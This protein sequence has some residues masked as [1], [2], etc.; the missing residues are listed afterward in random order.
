M[1]IHK[2]GNRPKPDD[3]HEHVDQGSVLPDARR[4]ALF[5]QTGQRLPTVSHG[6]GIYLWDTEGKRYL[7]A[8]SGAFTANIGHG[9]ARV[10]ARAKQQLE[11]VSFAYRTQFEN[12]P[13]CEL[14]GLLAGLSTPELNRVF[15]VNSGSEA[16][17]AAIKLARQYWWASGERG[18]HMVIARRPSY[19]G[20]T[21]GALSCSDYAPLNIPF[22]PMLLP[23]RKIA[24]PFCYHCPLD[25]NYPTCGVACAHEL[26]QRI[27][28]LGAENVAAFIAEP[29][30][31]ASTGA[32]VP[33]EEY[34][35]LIE[36]I[37][38]DHR[39]LLIIDDVLTGCGRTGTFFGFDHWN[40]TPDIV[41]MSKGLSGGYTPIGACLASDD[42]VR[43]VVEG[44]GFMHGHTLA[45][46]PLSAAVSAEVV[47]VVVEDGL[48]SNA[49]EMGITMHE[50]LRELKSRYDV[51]G[52]VRGRGLLAGIEFVRDRDA[53]EPFPA[54]WFVA[55]SATELA[56]SRGLIVYPRRSKY[57]LGGD[58]ILIAPPLIIDRAGIDEM[59][60]LLDATL[61][62]VTRYLRSFVRPAVA[63][64]RTFE[65]FQPTLDAPPQQV[66]TLDDIPEVPLANA[67]F[68]MQSDELEV[69][70]EDALV[71]P[72]DPRGLTP[73]PE[74][75]DKDKGN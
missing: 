48:V 53:R 31:G 49:R 2:I 46:N 28:V 42:I 44:G 39:V 8:C 11:R 29:I 47:K 24:A 16:V 65:R 33:P 41:A 36:R 9:N 21:L 62:D 74:G 57:G 13:A 15:L 32:A 50:R 56:R 43:P 20:A 61:A 3:V 6:A 73:P 30:G 7:D 52:D 66:G 60:E 23:V 10:I 14:A 70:E 34:F 68:T 35:P 40:F 38:H 1:S 4:V 27:R 26:D 54:S 63:N 75:H 71:R 19:H 25:K 22:R 58:H 59:M 55:L 64:D 5:Y 72:S 17:E 12:E 45:G 51:I 18:K 67:T 37:C 69:P